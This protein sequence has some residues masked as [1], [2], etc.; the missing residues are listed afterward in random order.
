VLCSG[1]VAKAIN[2]DTRGVFRFAPLQGDTAGAMLP[3][4]P[5]DRRHWSV[6]YLDADGLRTSS[7][8]ALEI[9]RRLGGWWRPLAWC[10]IVPRGLRDFVYRFIARHRYRALGE[11]HSC[12]PLTP[13]QQA[14][15]LP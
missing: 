12:T 15:I 7:D 13:G 3:P 5:G 8:A 9:A 2:A 6:V 10:R 14:R 1:F 11:R 4:L